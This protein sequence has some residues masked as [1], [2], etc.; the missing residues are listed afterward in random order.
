MDYP[1]TPN[2][3][4]E[5]PRAN[6][7]VNPEILEGEAAE[8]L[9]APEGQREVETSVTGA[10]SSLSDRL[11]GAVDQNQLLRPR[12]NPHSSPVHIA[13]TRILMISDFHG[14]LD[15]P[16]F[17]KYYGSKREE[18]LGEVPLV[19]RQAV[20]QLL[21]SNRVQ[22]AVLSYIGAFSREKRLKT[23]NAIRE[24]NAY[25][26]D[27]GCEKRVGISI[28]DQ[29]SEKAGIIE[30]ARA[31]AFVDDKLK[32]CQQAVSQSG[33]SVFFVAER[34]SKDRSVFHVQSFSGFVDR[35]LGARFVP[36]E[37]SP[38][39]LAHFPIP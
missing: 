26:S 5:R 31:A 39:W 34:P 36:V 10:S 3:G 8:I 16:E 9:E 2:C 19:N 21:Q 15:T 30:R 33:A 24:L 27:K 28:C 1:D 37:D 14:V 18:T 38:P 7:P 23:T 6:P 22:L 29:A 12:P 35:V 4:S 32:T 20:Y 25:L 13:P 11:S 17:L